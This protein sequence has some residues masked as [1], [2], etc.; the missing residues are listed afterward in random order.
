MSCFLNVNTFIIY[1]FDFMNIIIIA[2]SG[3]M[4]TLL[5]KIVINTLLAA[6]IMIYTYQITWRVFDKG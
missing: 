1:S 6:E 2:L 4:A 3:N 5:S